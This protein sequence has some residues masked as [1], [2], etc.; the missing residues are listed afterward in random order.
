MSKLGKKLIKSLRQFIKDAEDGK[1]FRQ[2][3]VRRMKVKGKTVFA[4]EAFVAPIARNR[5]GKV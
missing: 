5:R 2:S 4:R 1:S 3:I